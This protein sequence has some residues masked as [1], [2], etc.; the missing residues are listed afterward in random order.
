MKH[1]W[2]SWRWLLLAPLLL[3]AAEPVRSQT[4]QPERPA[5]QTAEQKKHLEQARACEEQARSLWKQGKYAEAI[6]TWQRKLGHER[7]A[8]GKDHVNLLPS[9]QALAQLQETADDCAAAGKTMQEVAAI[10]TRVRGPGDWRTVNARRQAAELLV[11]AGLKP[12]DRAALRQADSLGERTISLYRA[13][14]YGEALEAGEQAL[15]IRRRILGPDHTEVATTLNHLAL[16][17]QERGEFDRAEPLIRRSLRIREARL[18]KLHPDVANSLNTLALLCHHQ[19]QYDQAETLYRR[20][21]HIVETCLGKDHLFVAH[22]LNNLADLASLKADYAQAE[23]C[24]RRCLQIYETR[25][26]KDHPNVAICLNNLGQMFKKQGLFDRAESLCLRSLQIREARLGKDHPDV[27]NSLNNLGVICSNQAQY[28]RA[29]TLLQR[30]LHIFQARLGKD[31]PRVADLL[32]NLACMYHGQGKLAQA[33]LLHRRALEIRETRLGKDDHLVANS[34]NNLAGVYH[35]QGNYPQAE[36]LHRRALAIREARHGP[37]HPDVVESLNNLAALFASSRR[38]EEAA[39]ATDRARRRNCRHLCR[40]LPALSPQDQLAYLHNRVRL[41]LHAALA[42]AL[43]RRQDSGLAEA[44]A[45]WLANGKGLTQQALAEPLL[46]A[47]TGNR[48][49]LRDLLTRLTDTRRQLANLTL[50]TPRPGQE[51]QHRALLAALS[52]RE[53]DLA[54]ELRQQSG[55]HLPETSWVEPPAIRA[56]IPADARLVD[57]ARFPGIDYRARA[58]GAKWLP[59]RYV[60]WVIPPQ[61]QGRV[62]IIDLGPAAR[63]EAAVL[64]VRQALQAAP[65]AIAKQ[66]E[67]AAETVLRRSLA[68]LARQV[69]HPLLPHAGK[70]KHWLL[71]PDAALWLVPWAALPLPDG[72]Y[73]AERHTISCLVSGRDLVRPQAQGKAGQETVILADPDFDGNPARAVPRRQQGA[74]E[75]GGQSPRQGLRSAARLPRFG[76]LPG[77]AAEARAITPVLRRFTG[78]VPLVFTGKEA[79]EGVVKR[80]RRPRLLVLSTHGFFLEDQDPAAVALPAVLDRGLKMLRPEDPRPRKDRVPALENPLLRCG[81]ALAGANRRAAAPA[82]G[83]DGVLTGLEVVGLDLRGCEL[84][85]LSACDTALGKVNVGEGVAGLRQAFQLA[86]AETVLATLWQIPDA[87]TAQLMTGFFG[88]VASGRDKAKALARVQRT[89][90]Q[91]R[92]KQRGAAHPFYWAAFTLSGR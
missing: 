7:A 90:I 59:P 23:G 18:G 71:S 83:D 29:E 78:K 75:A 89:L 76:R 22:C 13:G 49:E 88:E 10:L 44:S 42:L 4:G 25:L 50:S 2:D 19:G 16:V 3:V 26:G 63:I 74:S 73:A 1:R 20:S 60:A 12:A 48:P 85:V 5:P 36:R 32:N 72:S 37:D 40:I 87:E 64:A 34:L 27:A 69:L 21:L 65:K 68:A 39:Q 30:S 54:R 41:E 35:D 24:Y 86:G 91:Q 82:D 46:L 53:E 6:K 31:H 33:E 47:H 17:Y 11:L 92:R 14:R 70:S 8:W 15:V 45:A 66:G 52:R 57:I 77:T 61:G 28:D 9:L 81:L 56:A 55:R 58:I 84:V 38:W 79:Q 62:E 80:L 67:A 43:E 51:K